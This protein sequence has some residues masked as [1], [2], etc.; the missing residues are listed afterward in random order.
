MGR[1]DTS[2]IAGCCSGRVRRGTHTFGQSIV[3]HSQNLLITAH[4]AAMSHPSL[5]VPI[6]VENDGRYLRK[7]PLKHVVDFDNGY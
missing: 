2:Q 7:Q 5:V 4:I 3:G 6:F 1:T